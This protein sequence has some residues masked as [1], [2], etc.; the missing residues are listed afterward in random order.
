MA[1]DGIRSSTILLGALG[2]LV[3]FGAGMY[4]TTFISS[5]PDQP[6][7]IT[8]STIEPAAPNTGL[9]GA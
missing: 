9:T 3:L 4:A 6:Q 7:K 8:L 1:K 5:G 2:V